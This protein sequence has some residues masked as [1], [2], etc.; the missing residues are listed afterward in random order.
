L[1]SS[2]GGG[3]SSRLYQRLVA[4]EHVA[5]IAQAMQY[6]LE[7]A[8]GFGAGAALSP[9]GGGPARTLV[10]LRAEVERLRNEGVNE[11]E[12]DKARNQAVSRL[13]LEA[14]SVSGK[15][16]LIGRAAVI[17]RGVAEL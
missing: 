2:L 4:E 14:Q 1:A 6:G 5:V 7:R 3:E 12:L 17:G 8:G 9:L 10:A 16:Q 11:E 15:A 13:L